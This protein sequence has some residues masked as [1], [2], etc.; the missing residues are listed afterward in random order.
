MAV[1]QD[2]NI[3]ISDEDL[4]QIDEIL[5]E[6]D[7]QFVK[8]LESIQ[9]DNLDHHDIGLP[10]ED[11]VNKKDKWYYRFWHNL[12]S[13]KQK[14]FLVSAF[15]FFVGIP[16]ILISFFG[17]LTPRFQIAETKS[18]QYLADETISVDGQAPMKNLMDL[19]LFDQF[20]LEIPEQVFIMKPLNDVRMGRFSFY[21]ELF[22]R[23][24]S[25]YF[26]KHY[27]EIVEILSRTLKQ[28]TYESF[29]GIEGKEQMKKVILAAL[30]GR[31]DAKVKNVRYKLLVF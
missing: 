12:D 5:E 14:W 15:I 23:E 16:A 24:D 22:S 9:A 6:A 18:L 7:P 25:T 30:N 17:V 8:E 27:E 4:A 29:K 1:E 19:F 2:E 10:T 26:E 21:L 11:E 13:K 31:L 28:Y 20:F 3:E